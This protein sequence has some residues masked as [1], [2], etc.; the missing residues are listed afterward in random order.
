MN[1]PALKYIAFTMKL[2]KIIDILLNVLLPVLTG[3]LIYLFTINNSRY[4]W[5]RN[6]LPDGLWAY[7][8]LSSILIIWNR[9]INIYWCSQVFLFAAAF[10]ILQFYHFL[11]GT[12][13]IWD[14]ATYYLFFIIVLMAN[15]Y[16]LKQTIKQNEKNEK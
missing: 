4:E 15:K 7:A 10:E 5:A 2:S 14:I 3:Y 6:Y 1:H 12:G 9:K 11:G 8:F 13:D 16:F